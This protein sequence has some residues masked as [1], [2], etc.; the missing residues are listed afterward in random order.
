[1]V[2]VWVILALIGV[3][4]FLIAS[5]PKRGNPYRKQSSGAS[6]HSWRAPSSGSALDRGRMIRCH[7]CG[8]FFPANHLV[9]R[10]IEGNRLHFCSEECRDNFRYP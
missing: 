6:F 10:V 2:T 8:C 9:T 7:N 3:T 5:N 1:M 4:F